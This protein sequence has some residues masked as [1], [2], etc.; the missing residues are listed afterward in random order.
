V[1]A[2]FLGRAS[3]GR[4]RVFFLNCS[5]DPLFSCSIRQRRI[6]PDGLEPSLPGCRPGVVAAGPRDLFVRQ[7]RLIWSKRFEEPPAPDGHLAVLSS[8][9]G[10]SRGTRTHNSR[11]ANTCFRDR[12]LIRPDDFRNVFFKLQLPRINESSN[13]KGESRKETAGESLV[14]CAPCL[15]PAVFSLLSTRLSL[16]SFLLLYSPQANCGGWNRTSGLRVQSPASLTNS[17]CPA[18]FSFKLKS[19]HW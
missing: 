7:W 16:F 10:G 3:L 2:G 18:S 14:T 8:D 13:G 17:N 11:C 6:I 15:A 5:P 1:T 9:S 19:P 4:L 12:P